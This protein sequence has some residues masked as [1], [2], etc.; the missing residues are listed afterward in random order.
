MSLH[1]LFALLLGTNSPQ[2]FL[3]HLTDQTC[4]AAY[5]RIADSLGAEIT[6]R[7]EDVDSTRTLQVSVWNADPQQVRGALRSVSL[8]FCGEILR[9]TAPTGWSVS[10]ERHIAAFGRPATVVWTAT[11][12]TAGGVDSR[13]E[14]FSIVLSPG[15][16]RA[17]AFGIAWQHSGNGSSLSRDCGEWPK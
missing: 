5:V 10:I 14:G 7:C 3:P 1:L 8:G 6:A 9:A 11:D 12:S 4:D 2:S 16:R 17:R 15:W 13:I